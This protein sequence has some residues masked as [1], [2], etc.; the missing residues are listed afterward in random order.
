MKLIASLV[1]DQVLPR[2]GNPSQAE[3][4]GASSSEN[5]LVSEKVGGLAKSEN[6]SYDFSSL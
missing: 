6:R 2:K 1:S 5:V 4:Y 3:S